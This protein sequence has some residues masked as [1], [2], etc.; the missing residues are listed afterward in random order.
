MHGFRIKHKVSTPAEKT[1]GRRHNFFET[2]TALHQA[3][4]NI[5]GVPGSSWEFHWIAGEAVTSHLQCDP[6]FKFPVYWNCLHYKNI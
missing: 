5:C 1:C 6:H 2:E 3:S 4:L